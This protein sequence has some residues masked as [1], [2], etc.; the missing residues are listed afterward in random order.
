[1]TGDMGE[2]F[3]DMKAARKALRA[4]YGVE[5]PQCK[6]LRP[7]TNASILLPNQRCKVDNYRDPRERLTVDQEN[8]AYEDS[9][10]EIRK[11]ENGGHEGYV[12]MK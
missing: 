2:L 1:M 6:L 12:R 11:V 7:K 4:R 8:R 9:G 3:N 5:C 10:L